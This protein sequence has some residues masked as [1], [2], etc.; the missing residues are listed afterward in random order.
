MDSLLTKCLN[1][2]KQ[3]NTFGQN[4]NRKFISSHE[5]RKELFDYIRNIFK[6]IETNKQDGNLI[7]VTVIYF[8]R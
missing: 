8:D 3:S 4:N 1:N 7:F 5:L 6:Q 2:V